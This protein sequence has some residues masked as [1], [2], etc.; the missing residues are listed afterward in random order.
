MGST[1][2][3]ATIPCE[4]KMVEHRLNPWAGSYDGAPW[5]GLYCCACG[6]RVKM[7]HQ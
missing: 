7:I 5:S 4:H 1:P 3:P 6:I 2:T